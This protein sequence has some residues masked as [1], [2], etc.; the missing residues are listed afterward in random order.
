[1]S[2]S[3]PT[4]SIFRNPRRR[5]GMTMMVAEL[6]ILIPIIVVGGFLLLDAG[7]M[8]LQKQ[9]FSFVLIQ[10]ANYLVNLP[11]EEDQIKP[12]EGLIRDL[13]KKAGLG[14]TNLKVK[15]EK[16]TIGDNEA[17]SVIASAKFPLLQGSS[18][19]VEIT[20]QDIEVAIVPANRVCGAIA[21]SP[22]PYSYEAPSSGVSVYLPII[23]PRHPMPIWQFPYETAINNLHHVRGAAPPQTPPLPKNPYF[24]D[25]PSIY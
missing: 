15:V 8:S 7:L 5:S 13:A 14:F 16:T 17:L 2:G 10:V 20:M 11:P 3:M 18:L 23:Q 22:Y 19:P 21:I 4:M 1:M 25:L 12:A 6:T 24:I 9:K